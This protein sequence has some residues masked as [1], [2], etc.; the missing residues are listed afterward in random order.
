MLFPGLALIALIAAVTVGMSLAVVALLTQ[1]FDQT[2]PRLGGLAGLDTQRNHQQ[3]RAEENRLVH[4]GKNIGIFFSHYFLIKMCFYFNVIFS[5]NSI[6][7]FVCNFF[8]FFVM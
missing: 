5:C 2:A 6:D 3:R 8:F 1:A 4:P 7:R